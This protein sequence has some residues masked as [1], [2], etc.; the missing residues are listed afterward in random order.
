ML[1]LEVRVVVVLAVFVLGHLYGGGHGMESVGDGAELLVGESVLEGG[2]SHV[3]APEI[4]EGE[5]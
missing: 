4:L 3:G 1:F 2:S 5:Q